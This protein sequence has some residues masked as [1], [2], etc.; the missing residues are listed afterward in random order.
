MTTLYGALG[1]P[2]NDRSFI[3]DLGQRIVWDAV[4]G[5]LGELNQDLNSAIGVFVEETTDE[6]KRRYKLP[7]GGYMQERGSQSAPGAVKARGEWDV[8]FP[9]LDFSDQLAWDDVDWAYMTVQEMQR[10]LDSIRIRATN[11]VR[12]QILMGLFNNAAW[13]FQ[14]KTGRG[15]L[16]IQPLANGDGTVYPP[17]HGSED[18]SGDNHYL[19]SGYLAENISDT[20]D[21]LPTIRAEIEEHFGGQTMLGSNIVVFHNT[22]QTT[23][24][25]SLAD[26]TEVTERFLL[27]GANVDQLTGLPA[28]LPGTIK[29]RSD[30]VWCVEWAWIPAGYLLAVHLDAPKPLIRRVDPAATG[31][32]SGDLQLVTR[33]D[34]MPFRGS[35]YRSRFGM[36]VGNRL[37]GVV[38][39]L[40]T[41]GSYTAP[42]AYAR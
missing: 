19:E 36:G 28:N 6:F 22:A 14:D 29:G 13:S 3:N 10:Q 33:D 8:A 34:A 16:T 42:S 7:G 30:G 21:P 31:L 37:N 18:E 12:R 32:G 15:E 11:T 9:L 27:P 24:L 35:F 38:M 39:K 40:G 5:I 17:V 1:L 2:D 4:Q 26:F 25:S 23:K 41:S 20:N